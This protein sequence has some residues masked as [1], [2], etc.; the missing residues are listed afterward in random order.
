MKAEITKS[1]NV[2]VTGRRMKIYKQHMIHQRA[3]QCQPS[4]CDITRVA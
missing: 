2:N 3:E 4:S 1:R